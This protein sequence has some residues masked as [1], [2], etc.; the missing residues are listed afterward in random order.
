MAKLPPM[1]RYYGGK[2]RASGRYPEPLHGTII[3][4]FA[5]SAGYSH[6]YHDLNVILI[7]RDPVLAAVWRYLIGATADDIMGLPLVPP[8]A[9]LRDMGLPD[10]QRWLIGFWVN[11][12]VAEPCNILGSWGRSQWPDPAPSFWGPRCR[13]RLA[14]NVEK[15][16]HWRIIE[17]SYVDAPDVAASWFVDPPYNNKAGS[18]Y[19]H[20][21][22]GIDYAELAIWCRSR[23][24]QVIVCENAGADWLPFR[25]L[26]TMP[27]AAKDG[28]TRKRS[29]EAVWLSD[30][31]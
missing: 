10:P 16:N 9:D 19:R 12:G 2:H 8:G 27:G 28:A 14:T 21:P 18:Y 15:I 13:E 1:F 7:E 26:Y 30:D 5:G 25:T 3:E 23:R 31:A 4:P 20:G 17:G 22:D 11:N 6:R 24:G 29:T